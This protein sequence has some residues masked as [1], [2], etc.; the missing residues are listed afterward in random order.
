MMDLKGKKFVNYNGKVGV[1]KDVYENITIF[2]DGTRVDT[3]IL[4]NPKYFTL[5]PSGPVRDANNILKQPLVEQIS[6]DR[7]KIDPNSFFNQ[8]YSIAQEAEGQ[9]PAQR[10]FE[11]YNVD[12]TGATTHFDEEAEKEEILRRNR[13]LMEQRD[14]QVAKQANNFKG[15]IV[16]KILEEEG[17]KIENVMVPPSPELYQEQ[18][19][20][21]T[22][23]VQINSVMNNNNVTSNSFMDPMIA[24]FKR[25]KMNTD[26]KINLD[27]N[28]K[29]PNINYIKMMEESCDISIIEYLA[30]EFTENLLKNPNQIKDKI[31]DELRKL[32]EPKEKPRKKVESKPTIKRTTTPIKQETEEL[33]NEV[34]VKNKK[35]VPPLPTPPQDRYVKEGHEPSKPKNMK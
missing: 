15:G 23:A 3:S 20:R 13:H 6:V 25:T 5:I 10:Q 27:I 31:V 2:E 17:I 12:N 16:G 26:F 1:V 24:L 7:D 11:S 9:Y 18:I 34:P 33:N 22:S 4:M 30:T 8:R 21:G 29:I 35:V 32:I 28:N 14:I 19:A